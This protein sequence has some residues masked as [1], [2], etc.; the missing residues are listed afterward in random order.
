MIITSILR[1][2]A[3]FLSL[4]FLP[5]YL[6]LRTLRIKG[7]DW[8]ER[9]FLAVF[10]SVLLTSWLG[11]LLAEIALFSLRSLLLLLLIYSA[12]MALV[13]RTRLSWSGIPKPQLDIRYWLLVI[14]VIAGLLFF[15]P[16]E[17][18]LGTSD[19]GV[20]LG[21]GVNIARTGAIRAR[22]P[23]LTDLTGGIENDLLY[24]YRFPYGSELM[25]FFGD[26]V[27]IWD[28]EQGMLFSQ[29]NHLYQVWIAIFYSIFK[30]RVGMNPL[31]PLDLLGILGHFAS[32]P[33]M[34][35]VTPLFGLL[36]VIA[37]Y[38]AGKALFDDRVGLLASFLLAINVAQMWFS[39]WAMSE[40]L[41]QFLVWGALYCFAL[42]V[43]TVDR[44]FGLLAGF[45][46][47]LAV[48]SRADGIFLI[49]P[50]ALY[51]IYL[52]FTKKLCS[53]HLY[54]FVPFAGLLLHWLIHSLLFSRGQLS[55]ISRALPY[56]SSIGPLAVGAAVL[57]AALLILAFLNYDKLTR[58]LARLSSLGRWLR[59]ALALL[60][61]LLALYAYF[62]RPGT[63]D[64]QMVYYHPAGGM[65]R[66][67]N[68]ENL[69]RLG[70]YVTPLGLLLALGGLIAMILKASD[71]G[72]VFFLGTAMLY[73]FVFLHSGLVNPIHIYWIRRYI[74]VVIPSIMLFISYGL[75]R[76][77]KLKA[78]SAK[79][80]ARIVVIVLTIVLI[81]SFLRTSLA[82]AG[83]RPYLGAA[84]QLSRLAEQLSDRAVVIFEGPL[85]GDPLALPLTYLYG[86]DSFV[87]QG[88]SPNNE[89]FFD[90]VERWRDRGREVFYVAHDG[91]TRVRSDDDVF[92][93]VGEVSL[94]ISLPETSFDH[95][96]QGLVHH[97]YDLEI[98]RIE[99]AWKREGPIYPFALDVGRFD[100]GYLISGFYS[101]ENSGGGCYRWTG[102]TAEVQLPWASGGKD[103]VLSLTVGSPRP[104]GVEPAKVTLYLNGRLLDRFDL[105]DEFQTYTVLIPPDFMIGH[106]G[107]T[108]LLRLET[109]PW[110]PADAGLQDVRELGVVLDH[111]ELDKAP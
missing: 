69:V 85:I 26:G 70:W 20:Y 34:L 8:A 42:Y 99:P 87:L 64:P 107:K 67:Y 30:M 28:M 92:S 11:L 77:S 14:V 51:F 60:I 39:R 96:P 35:Y 1:T 88:Q 7:L 48:L 102:K 44:C 45:G 23:L 61:V 106:Q 6:T 37:L 104:E 100:Y 16:F 74:A 38:F 24:S 81:A 13:F 68:E 32:T 4:L 29:Q 97:P 62:I 52:R 50:V 12:S 111:L 63:A 15:R 76:S 94:D 3:F 18:V 89:Q 31:A 105:G 95:L 84:W 27:R 25:R 57:I 75:L 22:D 53:G 72:V 90:L 41:T 73:T 103:L 93:P 55:A 66:T 82:V 21:M 65:I 79:R 86:R 109:N 83:Q 91:L 49:V 43:R 5:G 78:Q 98:Y 40:V 59:P 108:A 47:G 56:F 17:S 58:A 19:S 80:T 71:E 36:G 2:T 9:L 110:I 101:R 54:F 33:M 10:S 46:L